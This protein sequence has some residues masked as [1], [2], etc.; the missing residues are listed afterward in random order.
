VETYNRTYPIFVQLY[1]AL[2]KSFDD[3]SELQKRL[4]K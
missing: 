1:R 4:E 3:V 2:E